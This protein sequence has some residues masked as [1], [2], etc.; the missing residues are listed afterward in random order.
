ML[1]LTYLL[2]CVYNRTRGSSLAAILFHTSL[3]TSFLLL[4]IARAYQEWTLL[5]WLVALALCVGKQDRWEALPRS[6]D[7]APDYAPTPAP[8]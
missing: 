4:P 5:L 1:P 8:G 3:N 6:T 7:P 2:T